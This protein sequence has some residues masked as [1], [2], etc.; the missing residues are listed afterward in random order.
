MSNTAAPPP[1]P[2][3]I[4]LLPSA[5]MGHLT[6]FLRVAAML[7][8]RNC[9]VSLITACPS[10][11]AAESAHI[12]FFLSQ[13][14]KV[15]HIEFQ[16]ISFPN[17][18]T[19]DP[20]FLQFEATT[21]SVHLLYPSLAASSPP[22]SAI[23][24]DCAV[25]SSIASVAADLGVPN[26]IIF[27]SSWI[28]MNT[29][30]DFEPETLAAINSGMV[31]ENLPPILP[32]GPLDTFEAK[33]EQDEDGD[34]LSW[35]D[36]QPSES[37]V[38]VSFGSRTAMSNEQI[39]ELSDGLERSGYRFLWVLKTSKV[40]KDDKED[41]KIVVKGWVSQQDIL[42]HAAIGGFVNH[43]GWNSVME[44]AHKGV[45]VLAWPQHGDQSV[46]AEVVEKAGLGIWER[47]WGWGVGGG[48]VVGGE[49]IGRKIA[50]LMEDKKL[51]GLARKVGEDAKKATA[52][53]GKSQKVFN[54]V[55]EY[56]TQKN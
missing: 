20:F 13:H 56:L 10:V 36:S 9:T 23:F 55:L 29:F 28:L 38:Y 2:P 14:P 50:E 18:T 5:G 6:P 53:G 19:D 44:A 15:N 27:T 21:R 54:E 7:S 1:P 43:C 11:S 22:V 17:P 33:K 48:V 41:L 51:R 34:Y 37:V 30:E 35:L 31:L 49:E 47:S 40:D 42:E 32:I 39:K 16:V 25:A 8:S 26:Y 24:S 3:H 4:A 46:N 45:P 12:S 52:T